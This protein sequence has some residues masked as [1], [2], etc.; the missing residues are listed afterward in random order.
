MKVVAVTHGENVG[1]GVFGDVVRERGHELAGWS[2]AYGGEAPHDAAA[3]LV[4]GGGMHVDQE[5]RHPW[6]LRE[7]DFLRRMLD[8]GTPVLGVCLGAQ[9]L[10]RAA[11]AH[12]GPAPEPEVGWC[13]V[14][15]TDAG[16]ADPVLSALPERFDAFQWHHY[17]FD[18]PA[19]ATE[20]ARSPVC[21][22][23]FRLGAARGIQFH[24][25]VTGA[26]TAAWLREDP[27]DVADPDAFSAETERRLPAWNELG[28]RL[29]SAFL[30]EVG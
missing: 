15:L 9:L 28:R 11:G 17:A 1:A 13:G 3:V 10:A 16:R 24:A 18:V 25:E 7:L 26:M 2:I 5:D 6:L 12:V 23:A 21:A 29:C 19:G 30:D 14:E 8:H 22:Q 4:F 27:A 20:L